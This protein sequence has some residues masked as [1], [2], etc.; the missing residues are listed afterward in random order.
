MKRD[1]EMYPGG[2]KKFLYA[3]SSSRKSAKSEDDK[4][5]FT[6]KNTG[7]SGKESRF[8]LENVWSIK[9]VALKKS[10]DKGDQLNLN[11]NTNFYSRHG[12]LKDRTDSGPSAESSYPSFASSGGEHSWTTSRR[13]FSYSTNQTPPT[14]GQGNGDRNSASSFQGPEDG[15]GL[16]DD[17][18]PINGLRYGHST[19]NSDPFRF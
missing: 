4:W 1:Q 18:Q 15:P 11:V 8:D 17:R 19:K 9:N 7:S 6:G 2:T 12:V 16:S 14:I 3:G 10:Q 5:S 13:G